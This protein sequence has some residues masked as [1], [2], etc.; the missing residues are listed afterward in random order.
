MSTSPTLKR[1]ATRWQILGISVNAVIGSGVY[2]LP[3]S[4]AALLGPTSLLAVPLVGAAVLL[5]GFCFA[6]AGSRFDEAGGAYV[7]T[8]EAFGDFAGFQVGWLSWLSKVASNAAIWN[9]LTQALAFYWPQASTSAT[10]AAVITLGVGFVTW[11]NV[12]GM[13]QAANLNTGFAVAKVLP[14][15]LLIL[16]GLPVL[17]WSLIVPMPMPGAGGLGAAVL[18]FLYAFAGFENTAVAAGEYEN[19]KRDVPFALVMNIV[20]VTLVY[21]LIQLVALGTLPDL[22]ARGG[23]APLADSALVVGGSWAAAIL[24]LGGAISMGG[25]LA[26]SGLTGPRFLYALS[27]DRFGPR[28][29]A[30]VHARYRTPAWAIITHEAILWGLALSGSFEQL[31]LLSIAA[32]IG[33]YMGAAAS[34]PFLRK[35]Y[36]ASENT[37]VLPGGATIP[38]LGVL[39]CLTFF[40]SLTIGKIMAGVIAIAVGCAVYFARREAPA[41]EPASESAVA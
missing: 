33:T 34:V 2:I 32:R 3:A 39:L 19:P 16:A 4:A 30:R 6:E 9:A 17:D 31:L 14:L 10:R 23:G 29:L 40:A 1:V 24:T 13:K 22:A 26:G 7:Y 41:L 12:I 27:V 5:L 28:Y 21:T 37:I 35:K 18:L 11:V 36:P 15:L 38:V 8:R 20:I 25:N